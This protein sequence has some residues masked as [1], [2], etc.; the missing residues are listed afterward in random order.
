MYCFLLKYLVKATIFIHCWLNFETNVFRPILNATVSNVILCFFSI[1]VILLRIVDKV[2]K[3][4]AK[5]ELL[6]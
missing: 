6:N 4:N 5:W 1:T 3:K 2:E